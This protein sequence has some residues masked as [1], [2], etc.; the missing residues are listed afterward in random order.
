MKLYHGTSSRFL[1]RILKSG[2]KPRGKGKGQWDKFPSRPD[3]VYLTTAYPFYFSIQAI[4]KKEPGLVLEIDSSKLNTEYLLPDEDYI[5]QRAMDVTGKDMDTLHK[6]V[7]KTLE[8]FQNR[9]LN[10][11]HELGNVAF[12]GTVPL[13]AI[14]RYCTIDFLAQPLFTHENLDPV[15]NLLNYGTVGGYYR[16]LVAWAFDDSKKWPEPF[17]EYPAENRAMLRREYPDREEAVRKAGMDRN[18]IEIVTVNGTKPKPSKKAAVKKAR[19]KRA[20]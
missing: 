3:L 10:S 7:W 6:S 19:V 12:K 2:I 9:W 15:I 13:E 16:Q 5:V 11:V 20:P 14:T 18:G 8:A 17:S 1:D 4:G